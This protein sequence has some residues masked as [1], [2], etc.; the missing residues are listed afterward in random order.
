MNKFNIPYTSEM[1]EAGDAYIR[2]KAYRGQYNLPVQFRW[3][4][5]FDAMLNTVPE[6]VKTA[7]VWHEGS[8]SFYRAILLEPIPSQGPVPDQSPIERLLSAIEGMQGQQIDYRVAL[9]LNA[10]YNR[11]KVEQLHSPKALA[12]ELEPI[13][14]LVQVSEA[15]TKN[16]SL[17]SVEEIESKR[18][19]LA[20]E[21][22][23]SLDDP[24]VQAA[25]TKWLDEELDKRGIRG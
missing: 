3:H 2:S 23:V 21:F 16:W 17:I 19:E 9:Q 6:Q 8:Q 13:E 20:W 10:I 25:L 12:T 14:I 22:E 18:H 7:D 5:L 11:L 15:V 24:A 4:E 1:G